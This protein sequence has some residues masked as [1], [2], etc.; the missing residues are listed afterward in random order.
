[1]SSFRTSLSQ[2][3]AGLAVGVLDAVRGSSLEE[4]FA[5][6]GVAAPRWLV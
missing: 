1:M 4:I 3:A 5:E 2:L 6:V